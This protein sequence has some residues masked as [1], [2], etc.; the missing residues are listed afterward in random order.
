V[1]LSQHFT[2]RL[3][4]WV[5][6][7]TVNHRIRAGKVDILKDTQGLSIYLFPVTIKAILVDN[8]YLAGLNLAEKAGAD[9]V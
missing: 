6:Q 1:F 8:N 7:S 9:V 4:R 2:H 3:P 5:K